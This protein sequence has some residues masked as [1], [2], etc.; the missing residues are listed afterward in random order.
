MR[1][2]H[3][4][5]W[6]LG[7]P[8][9]LA[10]RPLA[11]LV[12]AVLILGASMWYLR[13]E[14]GFRELRF[15]DANDY[16]QM[17]RQL[18]RGEGFT[19][20]QT[21]P[22]VLAWLEARDLPTEPPWPNVT[23]FP[24]IT[25]LNAFSFG[26][27][28]PNDLGAVLAGGLLL[29]VTGAAAFALGN[30]LFG[31]LAG[32]VA[33]A[34]IITS[35]TQLRFALSGLTEIGAAFFLVASALCLIVAC[36][37]ERRPIAAALT[38]GVV[39]GLAYLQ[40]GNLIVL[41]PIVVL[42]HWV[43]SRRRSLEATG[44]LLAGLAASAGPWMLRN[45]IHFGGPLVSLTG[46]RALLFHLVP[47][48]PFYAFTQYDKWSVVTE[49]ARGIFDSLAS[50]WHLTH[51]D[52]LFGREFAWLGPLFLVSVLAIRSRRVAVVWLFAL[53][54]FIGCAIL[55]LAT[56]NHA[57]YYHPFAPLLLTLV[58]G[59]AVGVVRR[60]PRWAHYSLPVLAVTVV[61][62]AAPPAFDNVG[63]R[64]PKA[65]RDKPVLD[66]IVKLVPPDAIVASNASWKLAWYCDR[67]SVRFLG[68]PEQL[69]RLDRDY[70]TVGAVYMEGREA[71]SFRRALAGT[72]LGDRFAEVH[73]F[74]NGAL[75]LAR[76]ELQMTSPTAMIGHVSRMA[77]AV[78]GDS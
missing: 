54:S 21:F 60:L 76:A 26:V 74:R 40:R 64:L 28:G 33:A 10:G 36:E 44:A 47:G 67:P 61:A 12:L 42:L 68:E 34:L 62:I 11:L 78:E 72:S 30:R 37:S 24:L 18:H 73:E 20:I 32:L 17:G 75:W 29:A 70:V 23:R 55:L 58:V 66:Q 22:Y 59:L 14:A 27:V 31:P 19:S 2:K 41:V 25:I 35:P 7:D 51:Y 38:L 45:S 8:T 49:N 4:G 5:R 77:A 3:P 65:P 9:P 50:G 48:D 71:D 16:A 63:R 57:R 39:T 43:G 46:E 1:D 15:A 52:Q 56:Y 69:E 13:Y 6:L 53:I